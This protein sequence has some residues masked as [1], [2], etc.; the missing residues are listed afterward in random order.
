M[1]KTNRFLHLFFLVKIKAIVF[2][3]EGIVVN[4]AVIVVI[5]GVIVVKIHQRE[6]TEFDCSNLRVHCRKLGSD[7]SNPW[8]DC[9]KNSSERAHGIGL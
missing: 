4:Y 2:R 6:S 5:H 9:R 3:Y 8:S 7:C 1:K